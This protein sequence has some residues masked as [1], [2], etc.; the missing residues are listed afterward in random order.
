[1]NQ[2]LNS[3]SGP[4]SRERATCVERNTVVGC[5]SLMRVNCERCDHQTLFPVATNQER[6]ISNQDFWDREVGSEVLGWKV[7]SFGRGFTLKDYSLRSA[8]E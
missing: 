1:M 6:G 8:R 5:V 3:F 2:S 7:Q 4:G